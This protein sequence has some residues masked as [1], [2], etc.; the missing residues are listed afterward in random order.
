MSP[1]KRTWTAPA[2]VALVFTLLAGLGVLVGL[3]LVLCGAQVL[4]TAV[5]VVGA[6]LG[7]P[8]S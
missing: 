5:R 2:V 4:I 1:R 6:L 3:P 7:L 8:P